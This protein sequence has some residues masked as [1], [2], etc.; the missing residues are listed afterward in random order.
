MTGRYDFLN[1][2]TVPAQLP[3]HLARIPE[4]KVIARTVSVKGFRLKSP[5]NAGNGRRRKSQNAAGNK[6]CPDLFEHALE[7]GKMFDHI[8]QGDRGESPA[9]EA[10]FR[11]RCGKSGNDCGNLQDVADIGNRIE[12]NI[13]AVRN[14]SRVPGGGK[15]GTER[16]A[17]VEQFLFGKGMPEIPGGKA[18]K[19]GQPRKAGSPYRF[20]I[21][22]IRFTVL[23]LVFIKKIGTGIGLA[24]C[25]QERQVFHPACRTDADGAVRRTRAHPG[26]ARRAA[27]RT[28]P[29]ST[30]SQK[31][32]GL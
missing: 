8:P 19:H 25:G 1:R 13:G 32:N 22:E 30:R 12:R 5:G 21:L 4:G 6:E 10:V 15:K 27:E 11:I 18:I 2:E 16:T 23:R 20:E 29:C 3:A 9:F 24:A 7:V 17:D 31:G 14:P 28:I 26:R